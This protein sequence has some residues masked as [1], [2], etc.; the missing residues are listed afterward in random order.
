ML[1]RGLGVAA[2]SQNSASE[3]F[4]FM[5]IPG[6]T[7]QQIQFNNSGVLDG[8]TGANTDGDHSAFGVGATIDNGATTDNNGDTYSPNCVLTIGETNTDPTGSNGVY[9][10]MIQNP[11][12]TPTNSTYALR[13][14]VIATGAA[15]EPNSTIN[16]GIFNQ[17]S[18][19][20]SEHQFEV[21]VM[22]AIVA[23]YG[24]G[25]IDNLGGFSILA[26]NEAGGD[27]GT[28]TGFY[29]FYDQGFGGNG[30]TTSTVQHFVV[31]GDTTNVWSGTIED[32]YGFYYASPR[33]AGEGT[34]TNQYAVYIE[35]VNTATGDNFAIKTGRL[36]M[37]FNTT[38]Y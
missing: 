19:T 36:V 7:N 27:V 2:A 9:L 15:S 5:C 4:Y 34:I 21:D 17:V 3:R 25:S 13:V 33:L 37:T 11:E 29:S 8:A 12:S 28:Y 24:T 20:G 14:D 31:A 22:D 26:G 6:G 16:M 18:Y 1:L 23:N 35:D 32:L 30:G 38:R 10:S